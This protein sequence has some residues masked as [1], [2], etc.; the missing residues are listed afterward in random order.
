VE[1]DEAPAPSDSGGSGPASSVGVGVCGGTDAP[2]E[3][4]RG[5]TAAADAKGRAPAARERRR[6]AAMEEAIAGGQ[7]ARRNGGGWSL[8]L[9][10]ETGRLGRGGRVWKTVRRALTLTD[11]A[12][13][14]VAGE[15][16]RER[17]GGRSLPL[18]GMPR[19][20]RFEGHVP[21]LC[22]HSTNYLS[23]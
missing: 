2:A 3:K 8:E 11:G 5:A 1:E 14:V 13:S 17:Q 20:V 15:R 16:S 12:D 10:T 21:R 7:G 23:D 22:H 18:S 19:I 6:R 4:R 9:G